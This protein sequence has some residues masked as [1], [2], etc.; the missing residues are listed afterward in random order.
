MNG[1]VEGVAQVYIPLYGLR[2]GC[3]GSILGIPGQVRFAMEY[4]PR[5]TVEVMPILLV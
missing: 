3:R 5:P 1:R 2:E 4:I